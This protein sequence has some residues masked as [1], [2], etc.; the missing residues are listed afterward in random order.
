MIQIHSIETK[1]YS[2]IKLRLKQNDKILQAFAHSGELHKCVRHQFNA[3]NSLKI[4]VRKINWYRL[5]E[6]DWLVKVSRLTPS[7]CSSIVGL[8]MLCWVVY[9]AWTLL[10]GNRQTA[11]WW[12]VT[13][14]WRAIWTGQAI[15]LRWCWPVGDHTKQM[16]FI[17]FD[18]WMNGFRS[19][20]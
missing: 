4:C 16:D 9:N 8:L 7:T 5:C 10:R 15:G 14:W 17:Q 19:I 6:R 13:R 1:K 18:L 3:L 20:M 12:A 2:K 11:C